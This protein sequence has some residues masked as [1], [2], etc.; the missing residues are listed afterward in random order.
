[1]SQWLGRSDGLSKGRKMRRQPLRRVELMMSNDQPSDLQTHRA[2]AGTRERSSKRHN[3]RKGSALQHL[4]TNP[5]A[6]EARAAT[7]ASLQVT[8]EAGF[9]IKM[10]RVQQGSSL[11]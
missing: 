11:R 5:A 8:G 2:G 10:A 3:C 6:A 9:F 1:M 7:G 4:D